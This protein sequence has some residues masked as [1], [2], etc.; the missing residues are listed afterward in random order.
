MCE[1]A[2]KEEGL[3][4][5]PLGGSKELRKV[6][7]FFKHRERISPTRVKGHYRGRGEQPPK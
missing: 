5:T 4:V 1:S 6:A 7:T 3:S 2:V